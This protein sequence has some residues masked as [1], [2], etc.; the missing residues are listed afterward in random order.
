MYMSRYG[1]RAINAVMPAYPRPE[2][3]YPQTEDE[4]IAIQLQQQSSYQFQHLPSSGNQR[5]SSSSMTEPSEY[6]SS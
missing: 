2:L 6:A 3:S 1:A 5:Y 4:S